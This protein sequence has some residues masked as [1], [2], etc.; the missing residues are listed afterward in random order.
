[1]CRTKSLTGAAMTELEGKLPLTA[2][3]DL[4]NVCPNYKVLDIGGDD[5]FQ[6]P[7]ADLPEAGRFAMNQG[8]RGRYDAPQAQSHGAP[9]TRYTSAIN[10]ATGRLRGRVE[11]DLQFGAG[12]GVMGHTTLRQ[13]LVRDRLN[14]K[15]NRTYRGGYTV[16]HGAETMNPFPEADDF[17][18]TVFVPRDMP[19]GLENIVDL[20]TAYWLCKGRGYHFHINPLWGWKPLGRDLRSGFQR[21]RVGEN[22]RSV[23]SPH[24]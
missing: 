23:P 2:D 17:G 16:H 24:H 18:I 15:I 12:H 13:N 20:N 10:P 9:V 22:V 14:A 4:F 3:Y 11:D 6:N 1:M 19:L 21:M 8:V 5:R 7:R